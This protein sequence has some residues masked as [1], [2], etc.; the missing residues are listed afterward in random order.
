MTDER[1]GIDWE[2]AKRRLRDSERALEAALTVGPERLEEVYRQRAAQLA[3]H[4]AE[5]E[6]RAAALR[7]LTFSLGAE[8]YALE[9]A[10]VVEV[11]PFANVTPVPDGPAALL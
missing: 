3:G 9:L 2:E 11:L 7:V 5:E 10:D 4:A 1:S 6:A 8:R